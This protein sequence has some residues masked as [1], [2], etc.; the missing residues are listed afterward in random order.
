MSDPIIYNGPHVGDPVGQLPA[1]DGGIVL[2]WS[3]E[4][5]DVVSA[6]MRAIGPVPEPPPLV[7]GGHVEVYYSHSEENPFDLSCPQLIYNQAGD[8][9]N[10]T[11]AKLYESKVVAWN[12]RAAI[13]HNAV[14]TMFAGRMKLTTQSEKP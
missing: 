11:L 3:Y 5:A 9:V 4:P 8:Q 1:P 6:M 12:A 2:V 7:E 10:E 14:Q 13:I